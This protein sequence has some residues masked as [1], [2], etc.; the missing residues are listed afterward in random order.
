MLKRKTTGFR[1][2]SALLAGLTVFFYCSEGFAKAHAAESAMRQRIEEAAKH[3]RVS[4]ERLEDPDAWW[5]REK[6][7]AAERRRASLEKMKLFAGQYESE[8]RAAQAA[9]EARRIIA[10]DARG[11][12]VLELAE[13]SARGLSRD[14]LE[15]RL[16]KASPVWAKAS[17]EG[18]ARKRTGPSEQPFSPARLKHLS[19]QPKTPRVLPFRG[20][21]TPEVKALYAG[22]LG[23]G[24]RVARWDG[25]EVA[26]EDVLRHGVRPPEVR[27]AS[28]A[29]DALGMLP[30]MGALPPPTEEDLAQTPETRRT[31]ELEALAASLGGKPL[32][33]YNYVHTRVKPEL[34]HGSKKGAVAT[35]EEGAGNDWDSA[36]LLVALLRASGVPARYEYGTVRL[37]RAQAEALTG[38]SDVTMAAWLLSRTGIPAAATSDGTGV[39]A[40]RA[41]VRAYVPYG[42]YRGAGPGGEKLWV[43]LDP[44]MKVMKHRQPVNLRGLVRFDAGAY[45]AAPT[46]KTPLEVFE[47]QLLA[48]AQQRNLCNTLEDA[49]W[50]AGID[51][52]DFRL[53]PS[54]HPARVEA[55]LFNVARPPATM[56]HQVEVNLDGEVHSFELA[57]LQSRTLALRYP[58]AT[59]ADEEAIARAGG[60]V[61]VVPYQVKVVPTL[62][63]EGVEVKRFAPVHPGTVQTLTV[64]TTFP[65]TSPALAV[66]QPVAGSVYSL[67]T[68]AGPP[69]THRLARLKSRVSEATG[70]AQVEAEVH[71]A[72]ALY[73]HRM[74]TATA[75][76]ADL[77]GHLPLRHVMEGLAGKALRF[78][79]L[80]GTPV[81]LAPGPYIFDVNAFQGVL[82]RDM[83]ASEVPH[84]L[85]LLGHHSSALEAK[86]WEEVL[87]TESM[88]AVRAL[89]VAASQQVP[90]YRL[91]KANP[92]DRAKL[93]LYP[94]ETLQHVDEAL[95]AGWTVTIPERPV[96]HHQYQNQ[97]GYILL[98]PVTG[99]GGY[100]IG[101]LLNGGISSERGGSEGPADDCSGCS[102]DEAPVGSTVDLSNGNF[103]E[104]WTDLT[105]PAP[106][107]PVVWARTYAS[108]AWGLT[109]LGYGWM[110][111]YGMYLRPEVDGGL[112]Y[113]TEDWREVRFTRTATGYTVAPGWHLTL[114]KLADGHR[115]RTKHGLVQEFNLEGKLRSVTDTSG[116]RVT[117]T[118]QAGL[119]TEVRDAN[120]QVALG[121]TYAGNKIATVTDR[122]GR[123]VSYEYQGDDLTK[124]TDVLGH[125]EAYAYDSAHNLVKRMDKRGKVWLSFHDSLSDRWVGGENPLGHRSS[126]HYDVVNRRT[127]YVDRTGAAW[128]REYNARGNPVALVDPLGN[129]KEMEWDAALN[130][131]SEKDGRGY[132]TR[133]EYDSQ[134]NLILQ[135]DVDQGGARYTYDSTFNLP[136]SVQRVGLPT[137]T[138]TYDVAG[139]LVSRLEAGNTTTYGY[140]ARGQL[141]TVTA[142]GEATTQL[143]YDASG[144][145]ESVKDA[146]GGVT[147]FGFDS[148]GHLVSTRDANGHTQTLEVDAAGQMLAMVDAMGA[149]T[150][151]TYDAAGNRLTQKDARG[152]E[153]RFTYDAAGRLT[154]VMDALGHTTTT[155]YDAEG[156]VVARVDARGARTTTRYDAAGRAVETTGPDGATTTVGW[157]ADVPTQPCAEVDALGNLTTTEF[158]VMG[159]VTRVVDALGRETRRAYD[160]AG[161]ILTE[162][163]VGEAPATYQYDGY[164]G[165]LQAVTRGPLTV[166]YE[167]DA[168][169]NRTKV[170]TGNQVT[171]YVY[172]K[173][174]RLLSEKNPLGVVTSFTYDAAGNRAS[175]TDGNGRTTSY[176]YDANGRLREVLFA[177]GSRYEYGYDALG[178]RTLEKSPTHE[179]RLAYDSLGRLQQVMDLSLGKTLAYT[180]DANGNRTSVSDGTLVHTYAYDRRNRLIQAMDSGG[181]RTLF[182]YD[183]A[184]RRTQVAR[185][186][187][188]ATTYAYDVAGQV[189]SIVHARSGTVLAGFA[190]TYDGKG[191]R[192]SKTFADGTSEVYAYDTGN[193]LTQVAYGPRRVVKYTLSSEGNAT[194]VDDKVRLSDNTQQSTYTAATFNAFNQLTQA[195]RQVCTVGCTTTDTVYAY[196]GNGNLKAETTGSQVKAYAWDMDNRLRGI[197][198]PD[199][200]VNVYEYDANGLRTMQATPSGITRYLLDGESV[201]A[202]F[203]SAGATKTSYLTNPQAVDEILSFEKDGVAFS[204]LT[205]ALGS[206]YAVADSSGAVV[207]GYSYDA[208]GDRK[209]T[210]SGPQLAFGFTGRE[211]DA[212]GLRYHRDRYADA[213]VG[214]WNQVDRLGMLAGANFYEY[215]G[216]KAVL[217]RDPSGM[218]ATNSMDALLLANFPAWLQ[219]A[220]EVGIVAGGMGAVASFAKRY[221]G[222]GREISV[223][224][225]ACVA[226]KE[227]ESRRVLYR[228]LSKKDLQEYSFHGYVLSEYARAGR[229]LSDAMSRATAHT[230]YFHMEETLAG[231]PWISVT[232]SPVTGLRYATTGGFDSEPSGRVMKITTMRASVPTEAGGKSA[233]EDQEELL[234]YKLGL[235][236]LDELLLVW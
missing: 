195:R 203:D 115:L 67:L 64:R 117:L 105:L 177:D 141:V 60:I 180:H 95:A 111:S 114:T 142:P 42:N 52:A 86:V 90:V 23:E 144:L 82:P 207:G 165:L 15:K 31:P 162:T 137:V 91:T 229:T 28:L 5:G 49:A 157:C 12:L 62:V 24:A 97:I 169:G 119:L 10:A 221:V 121:F 48:A 214:R 156:R 25:S 171:S 116:N 103:R 235:A 80:H 100:R 17:R 110:H 83:N 30:L 74:V 213:M 29:S 178:N 205:D 234:F 14:T 198:M 150:E 149:R 220:V 139:R 138:N 185:P 230:A 129:R 158:D 231:S 190:Y 155:E 167:Y 128:T 112:T 85:T 47:G 189:L 208:Y 68:A 210:G 88:S 233:A 6:L 176:T 77:Q 136:K 1:V 223:M 89:Q 96:N 3:L 7:A 166:M 9:R 56:R 126:V 179:R 69:S 16:A 236:G 209:T 21:L 108:R 164:R 147:H 187:G 215:V 109:G 182:E 160:S 55:S 194:I 222:V 27:L 102:R 132:V 113:L 11:P 186:N 181:R 20:H 39:L 45:L 93:E 133:Y 172:D 53:L 226:L 227:M 191:N 163:G 120:N 73:A 225:G 161:R 202:E 54:E 19:V 32:A 148:A 79:E 87:S 36:A 232:R 192:L 57:E 145:I 217:H 140:D 50:V 170:T 70:D 174:N 125:A 71:Y 98:N 224:V 104:T 40:E 41:W 26:V 22:V 219:I 188:V 197:T 154:Q 84:L 130:K 146:T 175:R 228:G 184:G 38:E 75:R 59:A 124:V 13:A 204:P 131:R 168:R 196:D 63:L 193:R 151:S 173:A 35:L 34:Y 99:E 2:L 33:L 123:T 135:T 94:P 37:S 8:I 218:I 51:E 211:H 66:H 106:G 101:Q 159:R 65:A 81:A 78:T 153:T 58:G 200:V 201:L 127:V 206:I 72:M 183:A 118:Y 143:T 76:V 107:L 4:R 199:G 92:D 134:G 44:G 18:A 152:H 43:R 216:G 122:V 46:P 212:S 61:H